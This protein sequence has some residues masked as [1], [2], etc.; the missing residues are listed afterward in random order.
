MNFHTDGDFVIYEQKKIIQCQLFTEGVG[1]F[2][3]N[4]KNLLTA[5]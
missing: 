4:R 3:I 2:F 1:V 5:I